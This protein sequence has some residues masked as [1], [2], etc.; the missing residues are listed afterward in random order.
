LSCLLPAPAGDIDSIGRLVSQLVDIEMGDDSHRKRYACHFLSTGDL[1]RLPDMAMTEFV[2][3][4]QF[5]PETGNVEYPQPCPI[6][7]RAE[8]LRVRE[9]E[10]LEGHWM[11]WGQLLP[12]DDVWAASAV[13][14][15]TVTLRLD[16]DPVVYAYRFRRGFV[17]E[18]TLPA[19]HW[20]RYAD[21]LVAATPLEEVTLTTWPTDEEL[22]RI[23]FGCFGGAIGQLLANV[24]KKALAKRWPAIKFSLP[25]V[26][27]RSPMRGAA[28]V[29]FGGQHIGQTSAVNVKRRPLRDTGALRSSIE[30][31]P[32]EGEQP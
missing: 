29:Y 21:E 32:S 27:G 10:L 20:L 24:A 25:P 8:P 6:R 14:P 22:L 9:R 11:R 16:G 15:S 28:E 17:A 5:N 4:P 31:R 13:E 3:L 12:T 19:A 26:Y 7:A 18:T 2:L 23:D 1:R 30:F